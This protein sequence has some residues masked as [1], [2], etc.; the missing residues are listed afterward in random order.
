MQYEKLV[1][2]KIPGY[3]KTEIKNLVGLVIPGNE[4]IDQ[5]IAIDEDVFIFHVSRMGY[6]HIMQDVISE[7][8]FLKTR[9][10]LKNLR[11][12]AIVDSQEAYDEIIQTDSYILE[13]LRNYGFDGCGTEKNNVIRLSEHKEINIKSSWFIS[14]AYSRLLSGLFPGQFDTPVKGGEGGIAFQEYIKYSVAGSRK[15]RETLVSNHQGKVGKNIYIS[16]RKENNY[17]RKALWDVIKSDGQLDIA[18]LSMKNWTNQDLVEQLVKKYNERYISLYDENAIENYMIESGFS[19]IELQDYS[20]EEQA[21]IYSNADTIVQL[22]GGGIYNCSMV[23]PE[24]KVIIIATTNAYDFWYRGILESAEINFVCLPDRPEGFVAEP[25]G[26][27]YARY[28]SEDIIRSL[29]NHI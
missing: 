12:L 22:E 27:H 21:T 4:N 10:G 18:K 7:F 11:M 24:A 13:V 16:N 25:G 20:L 19:V 15:V 6:F 5:A 17:L 23:K 2:H 29:R 1:S 3:V 14:A 28:S 9:P 26:D 8:E